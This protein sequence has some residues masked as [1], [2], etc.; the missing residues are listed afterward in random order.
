VVTTETK[1]RKKGRKNT[2]TMEI[3]ME[4]GLTDCNRTIKWSEH[5]YGSERIP[6]SVAIM[7]R[8]LMRAIAELEKA[9]TALRRAE[10]LY[11]R[12]KRDGIFPEKADGED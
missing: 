7:K 5:A 10:C 3:S 4:V 11:D 8:K 2:S 1:I 12:Q 6:N 9:Y